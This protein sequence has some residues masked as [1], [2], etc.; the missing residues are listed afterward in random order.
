MQNQ[1]SEINNFGLL[2]KYPP[3]PKVLDNETKEEPKKVQKKKFKK[4]R[5]IKLHKCNECKKK[6]SIAEQQLTCKC[7][8][9]FC[10]KHR[11]QA[12][13]D[14]PILKK[15]FDEEEFKQKCGLVGGG[16]F[17]QIEAL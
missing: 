10:P 2:Q 4:K 9:N 16:K 12:Q 11:L 15:Y 13:H 17:K 8:V 14:C 1:Y 7:G 6:L 5:K 3:K